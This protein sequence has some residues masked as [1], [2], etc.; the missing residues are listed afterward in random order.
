MW[1][2]DRLPEEKLCEQDHGSPRE[3]VLGLE[4]GTCLASESIL[5]KS[6]SE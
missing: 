5:L 2:G 4:A 6:P 1:M 3:G